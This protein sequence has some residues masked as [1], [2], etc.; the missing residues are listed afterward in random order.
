[1][2]H[3]VDLC[4]GLGGASEAMV[5]SNKWSVLRIDNNPL[6]AD[7][8]FMVMADGKSVYGKRTVFGTVY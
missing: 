2:L 6:L 1:M 4:A 5:R 8:P 7:V 3:M